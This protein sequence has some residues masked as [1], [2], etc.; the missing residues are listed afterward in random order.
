[1]L[2]PATSIYP[3]NPP[4]E[5]ETFASASG[6]AY[7]SKIILGTHVGT[8]IDTPG[9]IDKD[10]MNI[11]DL[12]LNIFVGPCR[13]LDFTHVSGSIKADDLK[14]KHIARGERILMKTNNSLRGF[15]TF[16]DDYVFLSGEGAQYLA[17]SGI[18][19][20]GI[21][22]FSVKQKGSADNTPHSALL[23]KVIP[24]VEGLDLKQVTEGT[25]DLIVLPLKLE[26]GDG[27]PARAILLE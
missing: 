25:Y 1:M 14:Q 7:N 20:C 6:T 24:I 10:G 18:I 4:F 22:A 21:D 19:L 27:A 26:T 11:D 3:G 15:T 23:E 8:H 16:Y 13:V 5:V 9:H 12:S 17:E 2:N